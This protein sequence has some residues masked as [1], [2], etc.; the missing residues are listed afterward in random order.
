LLYTTLV[1]R[2]GGWKVQHSTEVGSLDGCKY[3]FE[4]TDM[5]RIKGTTINTDALATG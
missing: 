2:K 1:R 5:D 4:V 3:R